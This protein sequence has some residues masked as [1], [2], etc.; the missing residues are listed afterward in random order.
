MLPAPLAE[1]GQRRLQSLGIPR[2]V[3]AQEMSPVE[4]RG[5]YSMGASGTS[6]VGVC[7]SW[8]SASSPSQ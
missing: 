2:T 3:P 4:R 8:S 7:P 6:Y 5:P 1:G